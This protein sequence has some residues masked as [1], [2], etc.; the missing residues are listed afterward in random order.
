MQLT[1]RKF[2]R[3][4]LGLRSSKPNSSKAAKDRTQLVVLK[5]GRH[6]PKDVYDKMD[7]EDRLKADKDKYKVFTKRILHQ[8]VIY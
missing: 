3:I 5:T 4:A 8:N 2:K 7:P 1:K 6:L